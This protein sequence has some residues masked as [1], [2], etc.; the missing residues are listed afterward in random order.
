MNIFNLR[1][2]LIRIIA[3]SALLAPSMLAGEE[4]VFITEF[5]AL[6]NHRKA[7]RG[8]LAAYGRRYLEGQYEA[9]LAAERDG[10]IDLGD[11][12]ARGLLIFVLHLAH[13]LMVADY[14]NGNS[15]SD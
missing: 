11:V 5:M 14:A 9:L 3:A 8:E 4:K 10:R 7:I 13:G 1:Q 15:I 12:P 2:R 6:A